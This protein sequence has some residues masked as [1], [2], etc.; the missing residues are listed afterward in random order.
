[1]TVYLFSALAIAGGA[2]ALTLALMADS[3]LT[4]LEKRKL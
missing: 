2:V 4:H 3:V 1:M